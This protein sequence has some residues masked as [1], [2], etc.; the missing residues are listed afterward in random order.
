LACIIPA[1][2][3]SSPDDPADALEVRFID[4]FFDNY[5]QSPMQKIV[6]DAMR[7]TDIAAAGRPYSEAGGSSVAWLHYFVVRAVETNSVP[8]SWQVAADRATKA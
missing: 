6:C 5:I 4:R 1:P 7:D 3:G 8:L 2:C